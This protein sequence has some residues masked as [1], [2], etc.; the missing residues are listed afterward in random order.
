MHNVHHISLA[1]EQGA[2]FEGRI[3]RAGDESALSAVVEGKGADQPAWEA[4]S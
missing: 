4:S 3:L 2:M 1:I